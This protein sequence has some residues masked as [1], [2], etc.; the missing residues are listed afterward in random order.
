MSV[1]TG[2]MLV[3]SLGDSSALASIMSWFKDSPLNE[4]GYEL[5]DLEK[6]ILSCQSWHPQ[7]QAVGTGYNYMPSELREELIARVKAADWGL[8]ENVVLIIQPEEGPS[9]V[10]TLEATVNPT[11]M[12]MSELESDAYGSGGPMSG[13]PRPVPCVIHPNQ[14]GKR[15]TI[16]PT[17]PR[18]PIKD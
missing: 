18:G 7:F 9:T 12:C 11:C 1:V 3:C 10:I 15:Q 13:K 6:G 16:F 4:D 5:E 8:S 17:Y 2:I 14:D